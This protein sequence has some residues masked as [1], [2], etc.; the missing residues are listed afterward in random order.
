MFQL[1]KTE[2]EKKVFEHYDEYH[3]VALITKWQ[4]LQIKN[5]TYFNS[6]L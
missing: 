1:T 6:S 2:Q 3:Y 5:T 4:E